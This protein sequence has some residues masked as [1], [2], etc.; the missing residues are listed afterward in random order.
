MPNRLKKQALAALAALL[1]AF[2]PVAALATPGDILFSDTFNRAA[3]AP[4]TTT[5]PA[6][7]GILVGPQTSGSNPRA[8]YTSN[9][10]VTVTS[11][12]FN[13]AVPA[14]RLQIWIRRG[15][16]AISE[17]PDTGEDFIVEYQRANSSWNQLAT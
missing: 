13:A 12:T 15:S 3:L 1:T 10:A 7:S 17:D 2:F 5:N 9:Q 14:A 8:G 16:D 6:V 11:P 4:W